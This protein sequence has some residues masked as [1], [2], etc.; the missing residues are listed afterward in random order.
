M[1]VLAGDL[2][3]LVMSDMA[4]NMSGTRAVDQP[5]AMYLAELALDTARSILRPGGSFVAK[6]FMGAGFDEFQREARRSFSQVVTR[7]P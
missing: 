3:D 7:K 4:P 2:V 1:A 5:R 6:L